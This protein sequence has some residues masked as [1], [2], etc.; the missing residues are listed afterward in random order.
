[1][2]GND[3]ACTAW[4]LKLALTGAC[5]LALLACSK[6]PDVGPSSAPSATSA[7]AAPTDSPAPAPAAPASAPVASGPVSVSTVTVTSRNVPVSLKAVGSVVSLANVDIRAQMTGVI[8]KVHIKEGQFV[9]AGDVLFTLDART[10][11]A[12]L[13][14]AQAQL[15]KDQAALNDAKRQLARS[16]DL[17]AKN[18]VSAAAVD[19]AMLQVES[20]S[21]AVASDKAAVQAAQVAVSYA[22]VTA[23]FAGRLGAI[24]TQLGS[25]VQ[26]NVT[27]LVN[28]VKLHPIAIAFT[29]PQAEFGGVFSSYQKSA[30]I[31]VSATT[32]EMPKPMVGRLDFVD[33]TIDAN[34]GTI[35]LKAVFDNA[36]NKLWPGLFANV[37]MEVR[38]LPNALVVPQAA[39]V[40]SVRGSVLFTVKEGKAVPKIVKIVYASGADAVVTGVEAGDVVVTDGKQNVRPGVAVVERAKDAPKDAPK[41]GAKDGAKDGPPKAATEAEKPAAK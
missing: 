29:I 4:S 21:A 23:P 26:A 30:A 18:F 24:N 3:S 20:Q 12:N 15:A 28:V 34:S 40:Q 14:K 37:D 35:K 11:E 13:L 5:A 41:D 39:I 25:I 22:R 7:P 9:K 17:V 6:T 16:Q 31:R 1:M 36:D 33:N 38:N 19:T 8:T 2:N 10:D 32:A 27:P